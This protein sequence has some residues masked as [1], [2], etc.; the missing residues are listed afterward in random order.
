[1]SYLQKWFLGIVIVAIIF[2]LFLGRWLGRAEMKL[3]Q[4][5]YYQSHP[6]VDYNPDGLPVPTIKVYFEALEHLKREEI[7][8]GK[9]AATIYRLRRDVS[10]CTASGDID[11]RGAVCVSGNNDGHPIEVPCPQIVWPAEQPKP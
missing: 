11:P 2:G 9:A 4:D 1:M 8:M 3:W 7:L 6:V 5:A 10:E